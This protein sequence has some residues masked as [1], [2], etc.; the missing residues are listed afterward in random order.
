M[1]LPGTKRKTSPPPPSGP[2]LIFAA[3][4]V[5]GRIEATPGGFAAVAASGQRIALC[6]TERDA[7]DALHNHL[8]CDRI[9]RLRRC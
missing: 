8:R 4:Q 7:V 2:R 3:G 6:P 5:V 1:A 9:A